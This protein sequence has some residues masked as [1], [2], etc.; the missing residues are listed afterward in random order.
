MAQPNFRTGG[1][2][3][4]RH[5]WRAALA[6]LALSACTG[7]N[8]LL[9]PQPP[10]RPPASSFGLARGEH[11]RL[12]ALFGGEYRA[13]QAKSALEGVMAQLVRANEAS[14]G[15]DLT[16]LNSPVPNAFALPG[17]QIYL[18][19]GL[20]AL[21]NDTAE[22]AAVIAHEMAHVMARH[23]NERIEQQQ[24]ANLTRRVS[25]EVLNDEA[26][27][28]GVQERSRAFLAS[29]SRQQELEADR[30]GVRLLAKAG[31][32]PYGASRFLFSLGRSTALRNVASD[33]P[34]R[35]DMLSTHPSTQERI[36]QT[37]SAARQIGAPG[38]G[39]RDRASWLTVVD[40]IAFGGD[41]KQ[42]AAKGRKY[43]N[44][45]LG[46]TFAAPD[47]M[48]LEAGSEAVLGQSRGGALALR[49]EGVRLD[50]GQTLETYVA[51]GWIEGMATSNVQKI[52]VDGRPGVTAEGKGKD[53]SFRLAAIQAEDRTYRFILAG[54]GNEDLDRPFQAMVTSFRKLGASDRSGM[55][56]LRLRVV[57]APAGATAETLAGMMADI[58]RP[59]EQFLVLNG[60][61]RGAALTPGQRYKIISE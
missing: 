51:S 15:F 43:V 7:D 11:Q 22:A 57:T 18:T 14:S 20:V 35:P 6:G 9:P 4:M 3:R 17:G 36:G 37:L 28:A 61:E 8:V 24:R 27:G 38:I 59:L 48:A 32:D 19:R 55:N 45:A 23:A 49:F 30:I 46:I 21:I 52:T 29:F 33:G 25:T 39:Q 34:A 12:L 53:W 1:L 40:G 42:G 41:P 26:G 50:A 13:P 60:L 56:A 31:Y 44:S 5:S 54:R 47:G 16:L 2:H 58:D 10:Q